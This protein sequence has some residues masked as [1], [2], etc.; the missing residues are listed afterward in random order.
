MRG[1]K[2]TR[3]HNEGRAC[4][5]ESF[6]IDGIR[7]VID[8][9]LKL[10]AGI[11]KFVDTDLGGAIAELADKSKND[12]KKLALWAA[13][14]AENV[15]H[16]FENKHPADNRPR[17][18][19]EAGR[20]WVS[21]GL[22]MSDAR[23]AA[24]ASHAAARDAVDEAACAAARAAGHAAA[25]AHVAGHAV[26]AAAYAAKAA[27]FAADSGTA[28]ARVAEEREW[29]WQLLLAYSDTL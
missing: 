3:E 23:A 6:G 2:V 5:R 7:K 8:A 11:V 9:A 25:T 19:I 29:Q 1:L 12:P 18:A 24:F 14:C 22:T 13:E 15:L 26:H 4:E 20:A 10:E 21:G 16:L 28:G 17:A 27:A